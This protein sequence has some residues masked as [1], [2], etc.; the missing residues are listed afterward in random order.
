M[1]GFP[2]FLSS[3][4]WPQHVDQ[5]C[6]IRALAGLQSAPHVDFVMVA[7]RA[8]PI[9]VSSW[10][11]ERC[12]LTSMNHLALEFCFFFLSAVSSRKLQLKFFC[13]QPLTF[14]NIWPAAKYI[15]KTISY[16]PSPKIC[17]VNIHYL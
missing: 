16:R 15:L 8:H 14:Y 1:P 10:K 11:G 4:V 3:I 7:L 12:W 13:L 6:H 5:S 2:I 9:G 17:L